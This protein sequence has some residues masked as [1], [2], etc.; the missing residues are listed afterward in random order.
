MGTGTSKSEVLRICA[1]ID[2]IG[3]P[4]HIRTLAHFASRCAYL[5]TNYLNTR[6]STCQVVPMPSPCLAASPLTACG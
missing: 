2:E 4:L 6:N 3:G 1:G 5:D